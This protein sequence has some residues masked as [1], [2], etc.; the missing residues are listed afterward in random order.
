MRRYISI[1]QSFEVTLD[2]VGTQVETK[3]VMG[4]LNEL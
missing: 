1:G 2:S 3:H 4:T